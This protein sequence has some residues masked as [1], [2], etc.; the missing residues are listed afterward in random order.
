MWI[1][2]KPLEAERFTRI[3]EVDPGIFEGPGHKKWR[4]L[5]EQATTMVDL[6]TGTVFQSTTLHGFHLV[7]VK[8]KSKI[9]SQH[10][11]ETGQGGGGGHGE[12]RRYDVVF[13]MNF[14]RTPGSKRDEFTVCLHRLMVG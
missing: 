6:D 11:T 4:R 13:R 1:E 14:P 12:E 3:S 10:N 9:G 2:Y 5:I 8:I 7:G